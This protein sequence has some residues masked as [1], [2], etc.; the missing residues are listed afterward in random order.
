MLDASLITSPVPPIAVMV[1]LLAAFAAPWLGHVSERA[2]AVVL[3]LACAL[4]VFL[5]ASFIP[6]VLNGTVYQAYLIKLTPVVWI[7][8]RVDAMGALFGSTAAMLW[9]LAMIFS[10]GYMADENKLSRYY[11]FSMLCLAW[12]MGVAYA[13][14]LLTFLIFYELFSIMTYPLVVHEETREAMAAGS[15]T[16]STSSSAAASCFS[17]SWSPSTSRARRR[18]RRRGFWTRAWTAPRC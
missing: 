7:H 10:A 4:E 14:N 18:S 17:A 6:G 15:S 11:S 9:L 8:L 5:A 13:G 2:R 12:T 1:P 16:S 3:A